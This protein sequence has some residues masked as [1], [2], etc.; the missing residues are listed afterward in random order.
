MKSK[1]KIKLRNPSRTS[2][3][4]QRI[5]RIFEL[6]RNVGTN[7]R[8]LFLTYASIVIV[9]IGLYVASLSFPAITD[10]LSASSRTPWGIVTSVF[11]HGGG[12]G[13]LV[14][15]L[16]V[17]FVFLI[18]FSVSNINSKTRQK[19]AM[20]IFV[21]TTIFIVAIISNFLWVELF[22]ENTSSGSSGVVFAAEGV[23]MAFSL[24]NTITT[25]RFGKRGGNEEKRV[26]ALWMLNFLVFFSI[27][28]Q[29]ILNP[30]EFL[31]VAPN[32]NSFVHGT[33]F[34]TGF[35]LS[36]IWCGARH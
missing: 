14:V 15:N 9:C 25:F 35:C 36:G 4:S 12:A 26:Q 3:I 1:Q 16:L 13:H 29:I 17:L 11:V 20:I 22:P 28:L 33:S 8:P 2:E 7:F 24:S 19:R 27:F 34:L 10:V 5:L 6:S 31:N 30:R 21:L 18:L 23:T 32:V